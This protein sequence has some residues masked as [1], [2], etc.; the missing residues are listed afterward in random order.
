[1][2]T[3][4][5]KVQNK[6]RIQNGTDRFQETQKC[7][8][9]IYRLSN[10]Q[11][12]PYIHEMKERLLGEQIP[13]EIMPKKIPDPPPLIMDQQPVATVVK[14]NSDGYGSHTSP[15]HHRT[16]RTPLMPRSSTDDL[17]CTD[18]NKHPKNAK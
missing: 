13:M 15:T 7:K 5:E 4:S 12:C 3:T 1:M 18:R 9:K 11:R 17:D 2:S 10:M 8:V 6:V 14:L 16:D